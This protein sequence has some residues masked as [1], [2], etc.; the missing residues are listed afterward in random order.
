MNKHPV[1]LLAV[2]CATTA[3]S[4]SRSSAI[5]EGS[6]NNR[7]L[8][9]NW[10]LTRQQLISIETWLAGRKMNCGFGLGSPPPANTV[11]LLT[12]S[13]GSRFMLGFYN[14]ASYSGVVETDGSC[15]YYAKA[16]EVSALRQAVGDV[17]TQSPRRALERPRVD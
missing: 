17:S 3:Y 10:S 14:Q 12:R 15:G 11:L 5:T 13:D 6:A 8:N 2:L 16:A 4:G 1:L 7:D 9:R